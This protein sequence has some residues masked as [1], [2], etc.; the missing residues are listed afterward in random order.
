MWI[1]GYCVV[2]AYIERQVCKDLTISKLKYLG[3]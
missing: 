1:F 2:L 3:T